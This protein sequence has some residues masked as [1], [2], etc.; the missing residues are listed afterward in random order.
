MWG[1]GALFEQQRA[2]YSPG[3]LEPCLDSYLGWGLWGKE[4]KLQGPVGSVLGYPGRSLVLLKAMGSPGG[5][6]VRAGCCECV[7]VG[8]S[9]HLPYPGLGTGLLTWKNTQFPVSFNPE[10][11]GDQSHCHNT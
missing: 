6:S 7:K 10:Q 4:S 11:A 8:K 2:S 9:L 5:I 1:R 3:H